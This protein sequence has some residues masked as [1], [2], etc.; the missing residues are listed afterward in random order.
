MTDEDYHRRLL[1]L[2]GRMTGC[3][4]DADSFWTRYTFRHPLKDFVVR[5]ENTNL[6]WTER[7]DWL[8]IA[9][10]EIRHSLP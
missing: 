5:V 4:V 1:K 8:Q 2:L 6:G 10:R 7:L 3:E 9:A